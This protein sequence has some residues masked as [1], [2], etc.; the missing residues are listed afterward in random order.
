MYYARPQSCRSI[1]V[2]SDVTDVD[3]DWMAAQRGHSFYHDVLHGSKI[4]RSDRTKF[5]TDVMRDVLAVL[6]TRHEYASI[7]LEK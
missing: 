2:K 6:D 5:E 1:A 4:F 3:S 7:K